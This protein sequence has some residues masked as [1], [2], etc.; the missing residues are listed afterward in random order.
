M[1]LM[2]GHVEFV[3]G[4][5]ELHGIPVVEHARPIGP[6]GDESER[7]EPPHDPDVRTAREVRPCV[8]G[9][10]RERAHRWPQTRSAAPKMAEESPR[11]ARAIRTSREST[12]A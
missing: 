8:A 11:P 4:E 5:G 6:P 12:V 7:R 3:E 10:E 9:P 2:L 1:G